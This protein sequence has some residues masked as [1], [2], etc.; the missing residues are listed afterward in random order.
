MK[1]GLPKN[2]KVQRE[3]LA[4][5]AVAAVLTYWIVRP[6]LGRGFWVDE[7]MTGWINQKSPRA[8]VE[9]C[10][11]YDIAL[12]LPYLCYWLGG[13]LFGG[14]EIGLRW[15]SV[16]LAALNL[17]ALFLAFRGSYG[18]RSWLLLLIPFLSTANWVA[19]E[20][21]YYAALALSCSLAHY[22]SAQFIQSRH[23][24]L[25]GVVLAWALPPLMHPLGAIVTLLNSLVVL[26][27]LTFQRRARA[28]LI[29]IASAALISAT[30]LLPFVLDD[31]G[32]QTYWPGRLDL[33]SVFREMGGFLISGRYLGDRWLPLTIVAGVS[34]LALAQMKRPLVVLALVTLWA[35]MAGFLILLSHYPVFQI[36]YT[37]PLL[38][39]WLIVLASTALVRTAN[40]PWSILARGASIVALLAMVWLSRSAI[41]Y[42]DRGIEL[43]AAARW[44]DQRAD[45]DDLIVA[46]PPDVANPLRYYLPGR[47]TNWGPEGIWA[48]ENMAHF[49]DVWSHF[50][51][52][53][54]RRL[55]LLHVTYY[56]DHDP[57]QTIRSV[58]ELGGAEVV[59]RVDFGHVRVS[60]VQVPLASP[61]HAAYMVETTIPEGPH[62]KK[63][64]W[65][66]EWCVNQAQKVYLWWMRLPGQEPS[67]H[68]RVSVRLTPS[69]RDLTPLEQMDGTPVPR[70]GKVTYFPDWWP[71]NELQVGRFE[72]TPTAAGDR[73][74]TLVAYLADGDGFTILDVLPIAEVTIVPC[75]GP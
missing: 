7:A 26:V 38:S 24:S 27:Y 63:V 18:K 65:D 33:A 30:L 72:L 57:T 5:F 9:W 4:F 60:Q 1:S 22:K 35:G 36:R 31:V 25:W 3:A 50:S 51:E 28:G 75:A 48:L 43:R 52:A 46:W 19:A 49:E 66:E 6:Q 32:R 16:L 11:A 41:D 47:V 37:L 58:L 8:I 59:D 69:R 20:A 70:S 45:A 53:R 17:T 12:P 29:C 39:S 40:R 68:F 23:T 34:L 42:P 14:S 10:A 56:D 13:R 61:S 44:V 2:P 15:T 73:W 62:L 54:G 64:S 21:R 67:Y 71:D 74:L 55:W